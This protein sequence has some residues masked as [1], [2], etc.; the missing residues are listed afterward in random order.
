MCLGLDLDFA[1]WLLSVRT[2]DRTSISS[3]AA[4][5]SVSNEEIMRR[6]HQ[7]VP[8]GGAA[9]CK[10]VLGI[11]II[12]ASARKHAWQRKFKRSVLH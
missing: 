2:R 7:C 1:L 3:G 6:E 5:K 8:G 10:L 9:I 4:G 12:N 11:P